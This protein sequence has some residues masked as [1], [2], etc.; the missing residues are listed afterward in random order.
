MNLPP[1]IRNLSRK[2]W[3]IIIGAVTVVISGVI[4]WFLSGALTE[5]GDDPGIPAFMRRP[6]ESSLYA[7]IEQKKV[8]IQDQETI[9]SRLPEVTAKLEGMKADIAAASKRLPREAQKAEMRQLIEDL[10]RQVGG[11]SKGVVIK[12][13][14]I[15]ESAPTAGRGGQSGGDM[16]T[17][18]YSTNCIT[19]MDGLIQFVNLIERNERFMT[20][21]GIQLSAG[22]VQPDTVAGK[23]DFKPHQVTLRIVTYIDQSGGRK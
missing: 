11:T 14:Q 17:V 13:V 21:E 18:E 19:D 2:H 22:G 12:G 8:A 10:A 23:L 4:L 7:Q 1:A 6:G 3:L 20:I 16:A 5:L 9:A 15:R